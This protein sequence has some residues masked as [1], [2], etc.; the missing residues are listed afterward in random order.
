MVRL[1]TRGSPLALAQATL[2]ADL[3]RSAHEEID[4]ELVVVETGGDRDQTRP[5]SVL[6]G[7]GIFVKEVQAAVLDGRADLAVHSAK[8]LPS[9]SPDGLCLCC[10]PERRDPADGLVGRSLAGLGP[11]ATVAT[12]S[13]R[14]RALLLDLRPDLHLVELRGNMERRIAQAGADGV[15]AVVVAMAALERLGRSEVVVERLDPEVFTPQ[16]A[17]GA[18]GLEARSGDAATRALLDVIDDRPARQCV[19]GERAFLVGIGAGCTVPAGAWCT[20]ADGEFTLRAV[21]AL[22]EGRPERIRLVGA[23]PVSLGD[24][25]AQVLGRLVDR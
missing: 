13:P 6:G 15:D 10:V 16:V 20:Q 4:C 11:G 19:E 12:G 18:I 3:L 8:D 9:I 2:V 25:A 23:D 5:L 17:Q 22:E 24:H 21:M 7:R 14:R 1:A